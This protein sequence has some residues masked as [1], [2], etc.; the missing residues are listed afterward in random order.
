MSTRVRVEALVCLAVAGLPLLAHDPHDPIVT[1][2]VSPDYAQDR[3]VIAATDA[4]SI[5]LQV[6]ALLQSTD[7]GVNWS[8]VAGLPNNAKM[9]SLAFSPAYGQDQTIYVAGG[10]GLF[11]TTNRG[12]SW[13]VLTR[14]PLQA[15]ALS[16]NFATDNTLFAVTNQR[17]ILKSTNRGGTLTVL[18]SPSALTSG[19]TAIAVSPNYALDKTLLLGASADGVFKSTNGGATWV[20]VTSGMPL[21]AVTALVF[22]PGFSADRTAF[23]ATFGSGVLVS[24]NGGNSWAASNSGITD[25]N[26]TSL[27]LSPG[28]LQD[29]TL[30]VTTAVSG[31]FQSNTQGTA[32]MPGEIIPRALS[33]LSSTHYQALAAA[34]GGAGTAL[35][36]ATY[37]GL[38]S[39]AGSPSSW[40]YI[41]TVPTRLIRGINL[42]PHY[43]QDQT[44]FANT[45]G[46]GNLWS[47]TGG[48]SWTFR[49]TGMLR[50]YTDAA[51]ISPNFAADGMA[52]SSTGDGLQRTSDRGATWQRMKMLGVITCPR[53]VAPSPNIAQDSTVLI[54]T[55]N[56]PGLSYPPTVTY[57]GQQY[58]NQGLFVSTDLGNNW[59]PTSLGGPPVDQILMSPA[60]ATDRT[61]FALSTLDGLY[62]STD[63]GMTWTQITTLPSSAGHI[64][65]MA[66]SPAFASDRV[67]FAG[68]AIGGIWKSADAGATWTLLSQTGSLHAMDIQLSPNYAADQTLF[69]GTVQK[70]VMKSA[71][72]GKTLSPLTS[73]PDSFVTA[74]GISPNFANDRTLF[75]ASYHGLFKSTDGG[76]TWTYTAEPARI[77]ESRSTAAIAG[78]PPPTIVYQGLWSL[79]SPQPPAST[80]ASMSTAE[81]QDTTVLNFTGSGVRWVSRTGPTQGSATIQLDGV[82]EG[83]VSLTAPVDQYQQTVWE[84]HGLACGPHTFTLTALP[85]SGQTV[86]LDAFDIWVDTCPFTSLT[87]AH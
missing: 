75:A 35:Y 61:A 7:G 16:P 9:L 6:Y 31:V 28:Y 43:A 42:S 40:Q 84:Q 58:P 60:F 77:E 25:L 76:A 63:G 8:V 55:D 23:A 27:T 13:T 48:A 80:M 15:L 10:G 87:H 37:E 34:A 47:T 64:A 59:I 32:W 46:G 17:K 20:Q 12:T 65:V 82:S 1:V 39:A 44:L 5:K 85:Q 29:S 4:L 68:A 53:A 50:S 72:G 56:L 19:L 36:L 38:W 49:N 2:A 54:G 74:V 11:Q 51:A 24:T 73:Y 69:A 70:G 45:Y 57:Q 79:I 83:T 78:Q 86:L 52:F 62:K 14:Q 26:A 66:I 30:W 67:L 41:D 22:S 3:T 81:S 18:P 33:N 21:P 71:N